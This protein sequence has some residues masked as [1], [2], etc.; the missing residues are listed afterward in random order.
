MILENNSR[1]VLLSL[2]YTADDSSIKIFC[3]LSTQLYRF[4]SYPYC[5]SHINLSFEIILGIMFT[6]LFQ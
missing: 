1:N 2:I 5:V 6:E 3:I 4:I